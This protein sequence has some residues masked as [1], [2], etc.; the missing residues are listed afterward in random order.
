MLHQAVEEAKRKKEEAKRQVRKIGY[1]K[2]E[3]CLSALADIPEHRFLC[4]CV[5]V[6]VYLCACVCACVRMQ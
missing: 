6:C 2:P 5:C 3:P 4:V 1:L